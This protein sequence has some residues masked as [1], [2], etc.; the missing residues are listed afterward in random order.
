MSFAHVLHA[1]R[2]GR[3]G[4]REIRAGKEWWLH[5]RPRPD[6]RRAIAPLARYVATPRVGAARRT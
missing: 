6:M 5:Q 2:S 3:E 1:V 4:Q